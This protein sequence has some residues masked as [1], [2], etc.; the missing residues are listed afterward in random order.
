MTPT[1]SHQLLGWTARWTAGA[2]AR[3]SRREERLFN[4]RWAD[5]LAGREGEEWVEHR[6]ADHGLST[7]VRTCFF[8]DF[9]QRVTGQHAIRQVVLLAAGLDTRAFRLTWPE[10]TRLFELDQP[11]VLKDK[12][13]VLTAAGAQPTCKRKTIEVDLTGP[14]REKLLKAGFNSH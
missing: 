9:L 3:E 12:E 1:S 10:H 5:L 2:H 14:W 4:D 6:S 13:Q 8:D 11:Q 7:I